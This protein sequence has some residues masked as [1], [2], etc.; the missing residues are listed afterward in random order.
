MKLKT[1]IIVDRFIGNIIAYFLNFSARI[2][3]FCLRINHSLGKPFKTIVVSKFIGLGSIIQSTPLLQ[4]LRKKYPES[5]IIFVTGDDNVELLKHIDAVN[6]VIT[7]SDKTFLSLLTSTISLLLK[8]WR[9]R[10]DLYI[11]LE[12]YSNYSS[13][14]TTLSCA[15]NRFGFFKSDKNYRTGLY[16]HMMYFNVNSPVSEI[17]LQFARL[18]GC[19]EI[20]TN[21]MQLKIKEHDQSLMREKILKTT[22]IN[23]NSSYCII[24]PNASDLRIERRWDAE[25]YSLLIKKIIAEKP[26][27]TIVLI[28]NKKESQ[29][30]YEIIQK[31]GVKEKVVDS[32]GKLTLSELIYLIDKCSM[33]ITNDS[34]PMHIAFSIRKKTVALFGPCS[35]THYGFN[36]YCFPVYKKVYCSPCVHDFI[37]PPCKGDN[38]C[39]KK[40]TVDE[41]FK[42]IEVAFQNGV[43][44][45]RQEELIYTDN[46]NIP[47][48]VILR[49]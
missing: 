31:A 1:K 40:I 23:L 3:G 28:G 41:V 10:I 21:L 9:R 18:I 36:E 44:I 39:M 5:K 30:V 25:N 4:T 7:I 33:M 43:A 8:L 48:G 19:A 2:L 11:D 15:T 6:E 47:L 42:T 29:Y 16:T 22:G 27:L 46:N 37:T 12:I 20:I 26:Q 32:S 34:G 45:Y 24:N 13:I 38:Q 49:Q 14:V 17:Y 35:P